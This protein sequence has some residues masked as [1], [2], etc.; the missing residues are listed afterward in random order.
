MMGIAL[1]AGG[2]LQQLIA[3]VDSAGFT[4][5]GNAGVFFCERGGAH[6][7]DQSQHHKD[8]EKLFHDFDSFLK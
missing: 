6:S 3:S 1:Q 8:R 5:D 7:K 2:Q 4:V